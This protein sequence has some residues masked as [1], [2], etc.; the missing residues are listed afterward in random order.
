LFEGDMFETHVVEIEE[1]VD[2]KLRTASSRALEFV[3]QISRYCPL[4]THR[5]EV[6]IRDSQSEYLPPSR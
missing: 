2:A 6:M 3:V 1:H 4:S 5:S